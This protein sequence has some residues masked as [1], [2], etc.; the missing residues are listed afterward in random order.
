[1]SQDV[2][3]SGAKQSRFKSEIAAVAFGGLAM[4]AVLFSPA[5][6]TED[7]KVAAQVD[8]K[9]VAAGE[10]LTYAVTI[11]G[12][13][14]ESPKVQMDQFEGFQVV[15]T[16]Q[17]QQIQI[18]KGRPRQSLTL[19]YTL[20]PMVPGVHT[21]GPMKVQYQGHVYET[22]PIEV[23]VTGVSSGKRA[24]AVPEESPRSPELEGGTV[25]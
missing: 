25:L 3:A 24:P 14:K 18:E 7:L 16:S 10:L 12:S 21:L 23:K 15:A 11:A 5:A 22:Q 19:V 2:I 1:M 6:S 9:E 17:A 20:A 13:F 4:T 8:K